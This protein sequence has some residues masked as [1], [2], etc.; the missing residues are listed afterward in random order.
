[1]KRWMVKSMALGALALAAFGCE[2]KLTFSRFECIQTGDPADAV[3]ATLGQP[4]MKEER[5]WLYSDL[6]RQI[7]ATVYFQEG[8]VIGK[9]W[10]CPEHG[11]VGKSPYVNQPGDSHEIRYR[12]TK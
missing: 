6:D 10:H 7:Q 12:E 8:K 11:M 1:M 5:T 9:E 3:Q 4:T 2:Q